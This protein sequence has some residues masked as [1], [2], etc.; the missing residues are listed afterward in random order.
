LQ[1]PDAEQYQILRHEPKCVQLRDAQPPQF[2][3]LSR[4]FV[5]KYANTPLNGNAVINLQFNVLLISLKNV[6]QFTVKSAMF[7]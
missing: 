1:N 2:L 4:N 3:R 7:I 5:R 6:T